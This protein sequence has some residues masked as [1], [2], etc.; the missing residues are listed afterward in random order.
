[1]PEI[2]EGADVGIVAER[3]ADAIAGALEKVIALAA[4]EHT[5]ARCV[6][7]ARRWDWE[8]SVGPAHLELYER[9]R[10]LR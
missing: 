3:T 2:V 1:M 6:E 8:K 9:V 5:P 10:S 4:D 7:H